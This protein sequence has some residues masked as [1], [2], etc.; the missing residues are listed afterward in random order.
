[1]HRISHPFRVVFLFLTFE[2]MTDK[3][4]AD[5]YITDETK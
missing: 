5:E 2:T 4:S 3:M 1:M